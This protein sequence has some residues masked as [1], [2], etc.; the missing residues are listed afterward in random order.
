MAYFVISS[1]VY[2]LLFFIDLLVVHTLASY[3][4]P[5]IY[6][7]PLLRYVWMI[8]LYWTAFLLLGLYTRRMSALMETW[9]GLQAT[10]LAMIGVGTVLFLSKEGENYS[11]LIVLGYF[12]INLLIP[13]WMA[14]IR[15]RLMRL[16]WLRERALL[17]A[18]TQGE[19]RVRSWL[20]EEP[21]YGWELSV[22]LN[23]PDAGDRFEVP[24]GEWPVAIVVSDTLPLERTLALVETLQHRADRILL[25]PRST[26]LPLFQAEVVGALGRSGVAFDVRNRLF[27]PID[28]VVKAFSDLFLGLLLLI[29]LA[30]VLGVIALVIWLNDRSSP[31]YR[32]ERVGRQGRTFYI[33]KFR[34]M[35]PDAE[36]LL[37]RLLASD[38]ELREEWKREQ[39]L[40]NDP[41]ITSV[42]RFLRRS[43]LD[44]LPQL[45]NILRGEMSL[46]GP[47][48]VTEREASKYGESFQYYIAVRPGLTGLWQISGRNDLSYEE[49]VELDGWYVRNWSIS[50]DMM[51]L[52]KTF[53]IVWKQEGSY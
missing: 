41:R 46:V 18:D 6:R 36:E 13:F 5:D 53:G 30:P 16:P 19:R 20:N 37:E 32:Q 3:L 7:H 8:A 21:G 1:L 48:P 42:G 4:L 33:Y 15:K 51:I 10:G 27:D 47:R 31:I 23:P 34:T 44:E 25:L 9:R 14:G 50:L 12:L 39:K 22:R 40:K 2:L 11:R 49:R 29:L 45:F 35:R 17:V 38:P 52:I 28:R 43:S 24:D 26:R